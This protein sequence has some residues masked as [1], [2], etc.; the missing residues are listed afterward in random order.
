MDLIIS[1]GLLLISREDMHHFPGFMLISL[2]IC[3]FPMI[4]DYFPYF[5]A[6]L[7]LWTQPQ[8][9]F[10]R[11]LDLIISLRFLLISREDMHHFPG[12]MLISLD[13][14]VFPMIFDYFPYFFALLFLWTQPQLIFDRI[15]DL[16]ISLR[17][18]LISREDMH[19]FPKFMLISLDICAFPM[20]FDY[21][22]YFFALLPFLQITLKTS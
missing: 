21:F 12:F 14:C 18:L 20:I 2:D 22:P 13:I 7:F 11:I 5:F 17:F 19:H 4:F 16:I 8:L 3:V 10:D 15:L 6:L 1:Y 9:I